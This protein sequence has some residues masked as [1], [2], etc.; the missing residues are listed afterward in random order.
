MEDGQLLCEAAFDVVRHT[1]ARGTTNHQAELNTLLDI[2]LSA[3]LD[4]RRSNVS[5]GTV[6]VDMRR[7]NPSMVLP[8][9][10][11]VRKSERGWRAPPGINIL[12]SMEKT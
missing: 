7:S 1:C 3:N 2:L 10:A 11:V 5:I 12:R 8:G 4:L 9:N 6:Y